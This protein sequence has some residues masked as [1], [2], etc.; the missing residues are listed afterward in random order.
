MF[1]VQSLELGEL[2]RDRTARPRKTEYVPLHFSL[3]LEFPLDWQLQLISNCVI[4]HVIMT[5]KMTL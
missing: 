3:C 4:Q 1:S 5:F 2:K